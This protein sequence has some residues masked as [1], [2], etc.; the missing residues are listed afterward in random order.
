[1]S[2]SKCSRR[3]NYRK[4]ASSQN[5]QNMTA[6]Q[7]V[8]GMFYVGVMSTTSSSTTCYAEWFLFVFSK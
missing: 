1:M 8:E 6:V 7:A 3:Y 4:L 5:Q 2:R